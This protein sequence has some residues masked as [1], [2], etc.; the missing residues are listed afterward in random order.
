MLSTP[1]PYRPTTC[2]RAPACTTAGGTVAKHVRIASASSARATSSSSS[3]DSAIHISAPTRARACSSASIDG[4]GWSV[5]TTKNGRVMTPGSLRLAAGRADRCGVGSGRI[6]GRSH[7]LAVETRLLAHRHR[8]LEP[9]TILLDDL[10]DG[11]GQDQN[12]SGED[13]RVVGF[14]V[15]C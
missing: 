13:V 9:L 2:R 8:F 6:A 10:V 7:P 12:R 3:P 5:T 14:D 4:H 15:E 11:D 1:I